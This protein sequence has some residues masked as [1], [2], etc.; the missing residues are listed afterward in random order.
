[1]SLTLD[2]PPVFEPALRDG[3]R[4]L[5]TWRRDVRAFRPDPL[6]EGMIERL[7]ATACLAPSV[8]LSEPWRFVVVENAS[9][10]QAVRA[11]YEACNAAALAAQ[12][13]S[14]RA[15]YAKLKLAGL[16]QAPVHVAAFAE[17]DCDQGHG[18]GR[19]TM[20]S[21]LDYSVAIAIHTLWLA[22]RLE[23]VGLGWVSILDPKAVTAA[24][25]TPPSWRFIGYLCIGYPAEEHDVPALQRAGWDARRAPACRI[26]YR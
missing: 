24:L 2:L 9:T 16:D 25:A 7:I 13:G 21:A 8:G 10:R 4:E 23:G 11:N 12:D 14:R 15:L 19:Q 26:L 20:P 3:L 5:L 6:P 1:L 17:G 22:A 18:L